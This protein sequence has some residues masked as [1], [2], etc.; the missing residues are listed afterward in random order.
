MDEDRGLAYVTMSRNNSVG[1]VNLAGRKLESEIPVGIAPYTVV[2]HGQKAY[3]TNWGGRRPRDGEK[4][5]PTSGSRVLVDP[6]TGVASSGTVSVIDCASRR[7]VREINVQL[8]PCEMALSPDGSRLYVA[9]ANSDTVSV[10]DTR[11]DTVTDTLSVKPMAEL[12]FGCAPNALAV[13]PDGGT[14]YVCNGG[15]NAVAVIDL[16]SKRVTGLIPTGWYPGAIAVRD[17]VLYVG[18]TKGVVAITTETSKRSGQFSNNV[19]GLTRDHL[20][21]LSIVPVRPR[22][23]SRTIRPASPRM[24]MRLPKMHEALNARLWKRQKA[25]IPTLPGQ[26]SPI[27]H[28]L[29]IIKENRTYD[30][31]FGDMPQGNGD[32]RLVMFGREVTPNHHALAEQFVLLD[33][34][35][36]NGVLSAD[37]HQWTNEGY[38]TDY[39]E[40]SFGDFSRSYPYEGEDALAFSPS[41]FIW[42]YVLKAGLTFRDY[43][44]FVHAQITPNSATWADIYNDYKNGTKNVSIVATTKLH[45]LEPYLCPG[46]IASRKNA[47]RLS[48]PALHQ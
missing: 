9:N 43:G 18:N 40:K 16:S 21:S 47:R 6:K 17:N 39:L 46:V 38:V 48:R 4:T 29:Y 22:K 35:Y 13:S 36:C 24:N 19:T 41:G 23:N 34:F 44:E 32:P 33:N 42:D 12:T 10:I 20:G 1:I 11:S 31:V 26:V 25:T 2:L 28:V 45:T 37:G 30:Q 8:H 5:G 27:K 15:N 14:L 3:V 7:V